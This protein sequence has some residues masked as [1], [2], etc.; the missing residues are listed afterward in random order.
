MIELGKST[1]EK[2]VPHFNCSF[3][4]LFLS[5]AVGEKEDLTIRHTDGLWILYII[6]AQNIGY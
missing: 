1:T 6:I 3:Y 2:V 5:R 4:Q